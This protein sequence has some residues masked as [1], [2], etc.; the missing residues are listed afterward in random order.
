[1]SAT[2]ARQGGLV[3][4]ELSNMRLAWNM[5]KMAKGGFSRTAIGETQYVINISCTH[6][7]EDKNRGVEVAWHRKVMA[8]IERHPAMV[9]ENQ[10]AG[11]HSC[12]DGTPENPLT[13][14]RHEWRGAPPLDWPRQPTPQLT[15][16]QPRTPRTPSCDKERAQ[17]SQIECVPPGYMYIHTPP[18]N[19]QFFN[20]DAYAKDSKCDKDVIPDLQT[21]AGTSTG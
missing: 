5:A 3:Q 19:A 17:G 12:Q 2:I 6:V 4:L 14:W 11:Y 15:P 8:V 18:P 20:L 1:M 9:L 13:H 10:A 21:N 16:S 7:W